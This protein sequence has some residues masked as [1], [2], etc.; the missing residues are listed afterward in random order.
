[1]PEL[2]SHRANGPELALTAL[3]EIL[4]LRCAVF[5]V[6]QDCP[7]LDIDGRDLEPSTV[8]LWLADGTEIAAYV[9]VLAEPDG[10]S[11]IGR[12]VTAPAH[13][14]HHLS[15][16]LL[17]QALVTA[18]RPVVLAAQSHLV[19]LYARHGFLVDGPEFLEDGIPH[20]PMRL[21]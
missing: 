21:A 17:D 18:E 5:V 1:M 6:E 20:T 10:G 2:T 19:G 4:T 14:G 13:R 11:R 9:R 7:Y 8:H 12:V 3:Y 15:A 16:R